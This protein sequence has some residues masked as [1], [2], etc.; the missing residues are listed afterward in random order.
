MWYLYNWLY[1]LGVVLGFDVDVDCDDGSGFG[2]CVGFGFAI[3][4]FG[5][6]IVLVDCVC[7]EVMD[8][9]CEGL[10]YLYIIWV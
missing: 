5:C 6:E 3:D 7:I 10:W 1:G 9:I 8:V 4:V 2:L